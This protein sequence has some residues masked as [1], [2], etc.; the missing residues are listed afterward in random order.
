MN[1]LW[2]FTDRLAECATI[3][4][5]LFFFFRCMETKDMS[6]LVQWLITMGYAAIRL[7]YYATGWGY[8]PYAA[9][10][11]G[12]AFTWVMFECSWG[13]RLVW[14]ILSVVT[15]GIVD[16]LMTNTFLLFPEMSYALLRS[17][18]ITRTLYLII[19]RMMLYI[20]YRAM[21]MGTQKHKTI[22]GVNCALLLAVPVGC[23]MMLE[24]LLR[25]HQALDSALPLAWL[26]LMG[27]AALV[28]INIATVMQYNRLMAQEKQL[29]RAGVE[30]RVTQMTQTHI[31]QTK[32][33]YSKLARVKHD[34]KNH[35]AVISG[36]HQAENY[37]AIG[38]YIR[39]FTN[40]AN[41]QEALADDIGHP[42]VSTLIGT[43]SA[44]AK[45][46]GIAFS[47][48]VM[49][50]SALPISDVD[51][52][53]VMGNLLDNAFEAV[54]KARNDAH[55]FIDMTAR[56]IDNYWAVVCRNSTHD[57][58]IIHTSSNIRST[59][60]NGDAHGIGTLQMKDIAEKTGGFVTYQHA[61]YVFAA[62]VMIKMPQE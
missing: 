37:K 22:R 9:A 16:N 3:A 11:C 26:P 51:L 23:W 8:R 60:K 33:L 57:R 46:E 32:A 4:L 30:L 56:P 52:C 35:F 28:L 20:S 36:Y 19:T 18:G 50:P 48:N 24:V 54:E 44:L 14:V 15:D 41:A 2:F 38:E 12:L 47:A 49:L 39:E 27:S 42:V 40:E 17:P 43:K 10:I 7:A 59:K 61:D 53:I 34:L 21:T 58:G 1:I 6:K 45:E 5:A 62:I 31:E 25:Y 29:V 13:T 55:R